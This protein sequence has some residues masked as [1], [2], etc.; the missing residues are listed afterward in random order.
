MRN[1]VA[2]VGVFVIAAIAACGYDPHPES[3]ALP[4]TSHCPNGYV[5]Y[6]S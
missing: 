1:L 5:W 3:G 6:R 2:I 4:C